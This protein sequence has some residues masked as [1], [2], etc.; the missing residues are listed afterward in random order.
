[1]YSHANGLHRQALT[2]KILIAFLLILIGTAGCSSAPSETPEKFVKKFIQKQIPLLDQ[3]VANFYVKE[4]QA[5]VINRVKAFIE[6]KK[7]AGTLETLK[8]AKYD[9]SNIKIKV[10]DERDEY[11][12]DE[13]V[14]FV[15]VAATGSYTK[16][17]NGKSE[18][19]KED[20]IIILESIR[21][22]WKVTEKVNPWH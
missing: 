22:K 3:S 13:D 16:A 10:L 6:S 11:V 12:N 7:E 5:G 14:N 15:K 17:V 1:M 18:V 19:L 21:G 8:N 9:F 20:E 4:E 2:I